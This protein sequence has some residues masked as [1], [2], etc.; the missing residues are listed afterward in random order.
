M[1][2]ITRQLAD[3]SI[4]FTFAGLLASAVHAAKGR[5]IDALGCGLGG[6]DNEP[7]AIARRLARARS[8]RPSARV[9]GT[10]MR[11]TVEAAAFANTVAIRYLD[12]NDQYQGAKGSGHPSDVI[13]AVLAAADLTRGSV[14]DVIAAMVVGYEVF[15]ALA[16]Q[17]PIRDRGW[18]QGVFV[19]PATAA[20]T[21]RL[22]GLNREQLGEAIAIAATAY[23]A[24]RQTRA[25]DLSMWKG[26]ATAAAAQGGLWAALLAKEGMTGP[27]AAYSGY[28]GLWQQVTGEFELGPMG[29]SP[30]AIERSNYKLFPA[31]FHAQAPLSVAVEMRQQVGINL[32]AAI[33]IRTYNMLYGE[34]GSGDTKWD[35]Q[36]RETA[37]HSLPYMFAVA[38]QDGEIAPL[39]FSAERILDPALRPLMGKIHI[40]EEPAFTAVY[41]Q[42]LVSEIELLTTTGQRLVRRTDYPKGHVRNP[43]SDD[44]L[45]AKFRSLTRSHLGAEGADR[46]LAALWTL[47]QLGSAGAV[48]ELLDNGLT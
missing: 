36:T 7:A 28:D 3:Y 9:L 42:T 15:G 45:S 38:L 29:A 39:S 20:A 35:P 21:G 8:A 47:E 12:A 10:G 23:V 37:D 33:N 32:I 14:Q 18:D 24:T 30:L 22:L 19:A 44:D 41:P 1:D 34:I 25:G 26:A 16:E 27:T 6:F 13:G 43:M 46:A 2:A 4:S 40:T 11:T 31:E 5:L 17:V 48:M